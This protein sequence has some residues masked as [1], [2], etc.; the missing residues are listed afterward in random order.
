MLKQLEEVAAQKERDIELLEQQ[1]EAL[2]FRKRVLEKVLSVRDHQLS[3]MRRLRKDAPQ[4]PAAP[5]A[6]AGPDGNG[7]ASVSGI[8]SG[9]GSGSGPSPAEQ[10]HGAHG[11]TAG[12]QTAPAPGPGC[13]GAAS[14]PTVQVREGTVASVIGALSNAVGEADAE[15]FRSMGKVEFLEGWKAFTAEVTR[16]LL[17]LDSDPSDQA[18][19]EALRGLVRDGSFLFKHTSLLAPDTI[20]GALTTHMET[21][22]ARGP[23]PSHWRKVVAALDLSRVQLQELSAVFP[24][25]TVVMSDILQERRSINAAMA[26]GLE[27]ARGALAAEGSDGP[28]ASG[29]AAAAAAGGGGGGAEADGVVGSEVLAA[30]RVLRV[31]PESEVL[32][33]LQRNCRREKAA[34]LM[35]RGFL[36]GPCLSPLQFARAAVHSYPWV[37]DATAIIAAVAEAQAPDA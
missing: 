15:R 30:M 16:P 28:E 22:A 13:Q 5:A 1:N 19:A 3:V 8:G 2:R 20:M 25:F 32:Q 12:A 24:I 10:R 34:H 29:G 37:P 7:A 23:D 14:C 36:L 18:A 21:G 11:G 4:L 33:D 17:A 6:S 9:S 27:A 26:A 35:L 31:S